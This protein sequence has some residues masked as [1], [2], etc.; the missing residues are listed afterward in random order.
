[1]HTHLRYVPA[2]FV[3]EA[4]RPH[5]LKTDIALEHFKGPYLLGPW[6]NR[7][8]CAQVFGKDSREIPG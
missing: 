5:V 4:L 2:G 7:K 6:E 8:E 1:M 3:D